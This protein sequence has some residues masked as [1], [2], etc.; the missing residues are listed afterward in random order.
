[1]ASESPASAPPRERMSWLELG[2]GA[3]ELAAQV[4]AD[5]YRPESLK[6]LFGQ[7]AP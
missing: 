4:L 3:R 6:V 1:M 7:D 5:G 2:S